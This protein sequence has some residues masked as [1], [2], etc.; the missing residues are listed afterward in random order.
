MAQQLLRFKLTPLQL[1]GVIRESSSYHLT[2]IIA[3]DYS[4]P[5][6]LYPRTIWCILYTWLATTTGVLAIRTC[7]DMYLSIWWGSKLWNIL[8]TVTIWSKILK[9]KSLWGSQHAIF[10]ITSCLASQ[11]SSYLYLAWYSTLSLNM[12]ESSLLLQKVGVWPVKDTQR[13]IIYL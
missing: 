1:Q 7:L 11:S 10:G 6:M 8:T 5:Q 12:S 4:P 3:V 13:Y 9:K 2:D